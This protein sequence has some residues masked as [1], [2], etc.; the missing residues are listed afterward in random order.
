VV[1]IGECCPVSNENFL[2]IG[3]PVNGDTDDI[4][5]VLAFSVDD[6]KLDDSLVISLDYRFPAH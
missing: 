3:I 1:N 6:V 4:V 5:L 2:P